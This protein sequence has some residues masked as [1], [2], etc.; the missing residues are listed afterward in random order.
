[1]N[2]SLGGVTVAFFQRLRKMTFIEAC[3]YKLCMRI[4]SNVIFSFKLL[5]LSTEK[6]IGLGCEIYIF[7]SPPCSLFCVMSRQNISKTLLIKYIYK[8][9]F[10]Y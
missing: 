4:F 1:M 7:Y 5:N 9:Y 2:I 3:I 8:I 10:I 6:S